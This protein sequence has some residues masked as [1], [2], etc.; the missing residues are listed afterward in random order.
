MTDEVKQLL[1][2]HVGAAVIAIDQGE[3][4]FKQ[5]WGPRRIDQ[6]ELL[7]TPATNFRLASVSKH[8]TATAV[9]LLVDR[10]QLALDDTLAN[11][12]AD[13][14]DYWQSITVR[15]V[16]TH[17]SGLPDYEDHIPAGTT[18]QLSDLNVLAILR[19]TTEPLFTPGSKFAY[20]N[21]GYVLLGLVVE[22]ASGRPFHEF[23]RTEVFAPAGMER[24]VMYVTGVNSIA[25]RAFGHLPADGDPWQLADQS[26][27]SAVRGD[28]G[29]YSS[30]NDLEQWIAAVQHPGLLSE[31]SWQAMTTPHVK[32]D[33]GDAWYGYG[34][35][36]DEYRG[37]QR[38]YHAGDT[39]G[40]TLMLQR[41]PERRAAVAILLN[42]GDID[43]DDEEQYVRQ[44]VD[45]F[46][47]PANG[48]E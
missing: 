27:T 48:D 15:H 22:I 10:G 5:A 20:S 42:R 32:T 2:P 3:T 30:L 44:I 28:G 33:R 46:L 29:V 36:V 1:P 4:I 43:A 17:T 23:L 31:T 14:P 9:M 25:E 35:F 19:D 47:F 16:L 26:V 34:W 13:C 6:P 40:F 38:Y 11:V 37:E 39:R 41:F 45:H 24:S 8:F 18:L 12:F 21:S 7:C